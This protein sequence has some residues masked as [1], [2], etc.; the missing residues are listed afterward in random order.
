M[1]NHGGKR[2]GSGRKAI[3]IDLH[4]VEKLNA[5]HCTDPEIAACVGVSA[6]TYRERKKNKDF[7][8]VV[9][10][11]RAKG[12]IS[13]RRAQ[14]RLLEAGNAT[15][16]IWLGKR[17]LD[18]KDK[19][20][21]ME[22]QGPRVSVWRLSMKSLRARSRAQKL[23][24]LV[25]NPEMFAAH[26][27]RLDLR[28]KQQDILRSLESQPRVSV[29]ACPASGQTFLA[30]AAVLWYLARYQDIIVLTTAPTWLQVETVL[31]NEIRKIV[32]GSGITFPKPNATSLH[33][34]NRRYA[35]GLSPDQGS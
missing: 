23:A 35:I 33:L 24:K 28:P 25:A 18:Q 13:V 22:Q 27:L 11:G 3:E 16:A 34:G 19:T 31:W 20:Q 10:R 4:T 2:P 30:A 21:G 12:K 1:S 5:L 29:Q 15:M 7:A 9:S 17:W 32:A 8:E 26:S 6:R 14:V